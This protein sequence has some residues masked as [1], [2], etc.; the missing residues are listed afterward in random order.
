MKPILIGRLFLLTLVLACSRDPEP[1]SSSATSAPDTPD[2]VAQVVTRACISDPIVLRGF[3]RLED[4]RVRVGSVQYV[5]DGAR[6]W[7]AAVLAA[8]VLP[9]GTTLR[10]ES[11][12][13]P[14]SIA[15]LT[16]SLGSAP[17]GT[18][19]DLLTPIL[20]V[21]GDAGLSVEYVGSRAG[22]LALRA[23]SRVPGASG[24]FHA[25]EATSRQPIEF[26]RDGVPRPRAGSLV[27]DYGDFLDEFVARTMTVRVHR[28]EDAAVDACLLAELHTDGALV[29]RPGRVAAAGG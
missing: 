5:P 8:D 24:T 12:I 16:R 27:L 10:Q 17:Q 13:D 26:V 19:V 15:E 18:S 23:G 7:V 4:E 29:L 22:W 11:W 3:F 9:E 2:P 20:R 25:V 6:P 21:A 28:D 1:T 14:E